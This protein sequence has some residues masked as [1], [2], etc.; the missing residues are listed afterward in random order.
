M[1]NWLENYYIDED[2]YLLSKIEH[3]TKT[4]IRDVSSF[5]A[6]QLLRVIKKRVDSSSQG[7]MKKI[8][9]N[10]I[11]GPDP[12]YPKNMSKMKLLDLDP[13]EMARQ[14]TL[15]DFKLY[16][17]I[18]PIECLGKAWSKEDSNGLVA[19]NIKQS[20]HYC[21]RLTTLVTGTIL[22]PDEAKKRATMIKY[23]VQVAEVNILSYTISLYLICN[24]YRTVVI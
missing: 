5:A 11:S 16:S 9:P 19:T 8:I 6:N 3:F 23:W 14:L 15:M 20:I 24:I 22:K 13:V 2:A 7:E 17:S 1:K 4:N 21:N 10:P 12:I 18:R